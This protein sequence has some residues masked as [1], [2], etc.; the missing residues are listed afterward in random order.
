MS[1]PLLEVI[2]LDAVDADAAQAGGADRLE[3]VTDMA[4]DGLTPTTETLARIREAC[5]LPLRVML[6][7]RRDFS[8]GPAAHF[9][10]LLDQIPQLIAAGADGFVLGFL[11]QDCTIDE[12]AMRTVAQVIDR[13]WTCHRAVDNAANYDVAFAQVAKLPGVTE[14]LTAGHNGGIPLGLSNVLRHGATGK[15]LAGGGLGMAHIPKLYQQGVRAFHVGSGA[16]SSWNCAVERGMVRRWRE[17]IDAQ[18]C[19]K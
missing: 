6:R 5:D 8:A 14:V 10:A 2:V 7:V 12:Q 4:N 16:R 3:V 13:P 18:D 1:A 19:A 15:V 17:R 11:N 9:N